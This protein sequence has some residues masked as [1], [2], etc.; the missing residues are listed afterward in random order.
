MRQET[1]VHRHL[2]AC[3]FVF[4]DGGGIVDTGAFTSCLRGASKTTEPTESGESIYGLA[5]AP[6]DDSAIVTINVDSL[7][8]KRR[9][10]QI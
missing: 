2:Q 10:S 5:P 6:G 9:Q 8:N 1:W 4:L 3:T 7:R